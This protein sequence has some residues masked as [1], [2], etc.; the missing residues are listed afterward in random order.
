M[1]FGKFHKSLGGD[2]SVSLNAQLTAASGF[3]KYLPNN[4]KIPN[5]HNFFNNA[6]RFHYSKQ[7]PVIWLINKKHLR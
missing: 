6:H 7:I 2:I 3:E 4:D 5:F 1:F